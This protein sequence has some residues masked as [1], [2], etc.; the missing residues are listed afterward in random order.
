M[1][2]P[3]YRDI[4]WNKLTLSE[5]EEVCLLEE[6]A[7]LRRAIH[8]E[9]ISSKMG[10]KYFKS[11]YDA[12]IS[13]GKSPAK[14][15]RGF[16][17]KKTQNNQE[18]NRKLEKIVKN[19]KTLP[20]E[21]KKLGLSDLFLAD[22]IRYLN[23]PTK[24]GQLTLKIN[25][26]H[27]RLLEIEEVLV[28]TALMAAQ[29]IANKYSYSMLGLDKKDIVQE[30]NL[31][32]LEAIR[33]YDLG[34]KTDAGKR[35]KLITYAYY[36]MDKRIKDYIMQNSRLI[37]LPRSKLDR[38][39]VLL[40]ALANL[41]DRPSIIS[42]TR[43]I[44]FLLAKRKKKRLS[45]HQITEAFNLLRT[46]VISLDRN[47]G[48]TSSQRVS[49][50]DMIPDSSSGSPESNVTDLYS[51]ENLL[52]I[53]RNKLTLI[54]YRVIL[55]RFLEDK[56]TLSRQEVKKLLLERWKTH[57]SQERIRQIEEQALEKLR[58]VPQLS[59]LLGDI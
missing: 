44:N 3:Y 59:N 54:E 42:L 33:R 7:S 53:L 11:S 38:I 25:K 22:A 50:Q 55:L 36:V 46:N 56:F 8:D 35:V 41:K 9:I 48:T 28:S 34:F 14:L 31:G 32:L 10:Q 23:A 57:M 49:L 47:I 27:Q 6:F 2:D 17:S 1:T 40:E 5:E 29:E 21:L 51:Q 13:S 24:I 30:A 52:N 18:L 37:R 26:H 19:P 20:D 15:C 4:S 16:N 39:F 43:E 58:N 12:L 45:S